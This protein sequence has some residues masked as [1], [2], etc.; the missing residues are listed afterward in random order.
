LANDRLSVIQNAYP[1]NEGRDMVKQ[2]LKRV[3]VNGPW[4]KDKLIGQK[5]PLKLKEIWCIRI[6]LH[7]RNESGI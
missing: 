5:A 3:Q 2:E 4:N 1:I 6:C 7:Q